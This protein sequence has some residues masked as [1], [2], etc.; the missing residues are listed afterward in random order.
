VKKL[1]GVGIALTCLSALFLAP[2]ASAAQAAPGVTA[3]TIKVGVP[4]ID[5]ASLKS[6]GIDI[7]RGNY[8]DAYNALIASIN[9]HG[10]VNG[11]KIVPYY[12]AVSPTGTAAAQTSCTQLVQDDGVFVAIAPEQV[13]CY[14][15]TYHIPA[16]QGLMQTVN[17]AANFTLD[18][19]FRQ[20]DPA[21]LAIF[22]KHGVFNG[23]KLG[24]FAGSPT[25]KD[26]LAF[27]QSQLE[28]LHAKVV[29]SA[30]DSAP[31]TDQVA[32]YSQAQTIAERFQSS[33][34]NEVVAIGTGSALWPKALQSNQS[35]YN[36][37]W[38]ATSGEQLQ[39][40]V[41]KSMSP[42]Y[43]NNVWASTATPNIVSVWN[44]PQI[45][46]CA[47]IVKKAYPS[48]P[49][50]TPTL[51]TPGSKSTFISVVEAC[52]NLALFTKIADAAGKHLTISSFTNAGYG[53]RHVT[54][55]GIGAA[56]SFGPGQP[57]AVGPV[58]RL[59]YNSAIQTLVAENAPLK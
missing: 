49:I 26:E 50:G 41:D 21:E 19:P 8:P 37:S 2:A 28:K 20:Y 24:L 53:L 33:G 14:I 17:G 3:T 10:G 29:V 11:R 1:Y 44:D 4:Y 52:Q 9:A 35:S 43:V 7:D 34:V 22:N 38:V 57:A 47:S 48:D 40:S 15:G 25:D 6:L 31:S 32:E 59:T 42:Q 54:F 13:D 27:V 58:Y 5:Y 39:G 56:V 45:K 18:P 30:T 51:S 46:K 16:I 36:P 12:V 23:K 55:P